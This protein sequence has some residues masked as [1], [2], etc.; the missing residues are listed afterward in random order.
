M[1][2]SKFIYYSYK[3]KAVGFFCFPFLYKTNSGWYYN[4]NTTLANP[5]PINHSAFASDNVT[6]EMTHLLKINVSFLFLNYICNY[7]LFL[8]FKKRNLITFTMSTSLR[9]AAQARDALNYCRIKKSW[10]EIRERLLITNG[11]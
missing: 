7:Y 1:Q 11:I 4:N 2:F 8:V 3:V 6:I 5:W 10:R 9:G